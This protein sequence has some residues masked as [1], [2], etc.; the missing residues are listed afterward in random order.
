[1]GRREERCERG[2]DQRKGRAKQLEDCVALV[3]S[4]LYWLRER[5]FKTQNTF[6]VSLNGIEAKGSHCSL[7]PLE[8]LH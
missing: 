3:A 2:E 4:R 8:I 1:M 7:P 5:H 6:L